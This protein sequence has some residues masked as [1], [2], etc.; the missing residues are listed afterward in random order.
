MKDTDKIR[1]AFESENLYD[2]QRVSG[3]YRM[4][5]GSCLNDGD[6]LYKESRI[7]WEAYQRGQSDLIEA[8]GE[9]VAWKHKTADGW[10]RVFDTFSAK[11][12]PK[13]DEEYFRSPSIPLYR[14]P[15]DKPK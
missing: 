15:E 4:P 1:A 7:A 13:E 3:S 2:N 8:M 12:P 10:H 14:L 5:D 9:P 11:R 6:Y